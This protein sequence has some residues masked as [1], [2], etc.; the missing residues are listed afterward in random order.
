MNDAAVE[1]LGMLSGFAAIEPPEGLA[2]GL[3]ERVAS[4]IVRRGKVLTWASSVGGAEAAPSLFETL[5][6]WECSDSSFHLEDVV[7][8]EEVLTVDGAPVIMEEGQRTL[9]L[10]GVSFALRFSQSVYALDPP[11][12]VRCIVAVNETSG[13]FRFHQI[14]PGEEWNL[15]DL[16]GY[17]CE[18]VI[19]LDID[20]AGP[21][22]D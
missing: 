16:D 18:K 11:T 9:L 6:Q 3:Q 1:M 7:P 15:P 20:P 12:P 10:H 13:T 19:V 8:V 22:A 14:R 2:S 17:R 21:P 5:T 4:G